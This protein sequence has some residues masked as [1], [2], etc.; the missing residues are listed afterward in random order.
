M[1]CEINLW[2]LIRCTQP[3]VHNQPFFDALQQTPA[4]FDYIRMKIP[5]NVHE[6]GS[7][8]I[9]RFVDNPDWHLYAV[10]AKPGVPDRDG[11]VSND[12]AGSF[13]GSVGILD[14]R[15]NDAFTEVGAV[16][17][18]DILYTIHGA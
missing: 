2:Q 3:S 8:F 17:L 7:L 10:Y 15:Y 12:A 16:G 5:E 9:S 6:L 1:P 4:I 13:A 18:Q 11:H 14:S